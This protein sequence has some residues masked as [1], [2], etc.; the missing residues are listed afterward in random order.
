MEGVKEV[1]RKCDIKSGSNDES[2][3]HKKEE[4]DAWL[5]NEDEKDQNQLKKSLV[6]WLRGY[7]ELDEDWET[8]KEIKV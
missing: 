4:G 7:V 6:E 8:V 2:Y 3:L 5:M 1:M